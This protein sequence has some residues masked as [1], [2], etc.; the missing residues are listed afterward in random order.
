MKSHTLF[1]SD[2]HLCPQETHITHAFLDFLENTAPAADA[3]YILGDFFES[4]VGD[5][6]RTDFIN[7]IIEALAKLTKT[8]LPVFLMH[9]NRD[10][11]IGK[12][13]A[14]ASGV[15][16]IPDP[17]IITLYNQKLLLMHGDSLCTE[18]K[19]HQRFRKITGYKLVQKL[20]LLLPL[21]FRLKF[22]H[23]LREHSMQENRYKNVEIMDVSQKEV[24][25]VIKKYHADKLIHGHTHRPMISEKRIVLGSWETQGN[26]LAIDKQGTIQSIL[27]NK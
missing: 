1:I 10:F 21:S 11:L 2:L 13:F 18:D 7:S 3:L 23:D 27:P 14:A 20:F 16:L 12:Q 9:G 22:A 5:D 19:K 8:G 17:T 15:T 26:Y 25:R 6:N 24:D 4:Y